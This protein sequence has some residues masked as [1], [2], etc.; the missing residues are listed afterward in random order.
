MQ[1]SAVRSHSLNGFEHSVVQT[2]V[3]ARELSW[4]GS[5]MWATIELNVSPVCVRRRLD[6]P[7]SG[8]PGCVTQCPSSYKCR[9]DQI[10]WKESTSVIIATPNYKVPKSQSYLLHSLFRPVLKRQSAAFK[11]YDFLENKRGSKRYENLVKCKCVK[12]YMNQ[13]GFHDLSVLNFK[14]SG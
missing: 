14:G 6:L 8:P 3:M 7:G 1:T 2:L 11:K 13:S 12:W 4:E 10:V 9:R 5:A